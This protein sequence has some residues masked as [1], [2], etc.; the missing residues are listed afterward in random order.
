MIK[1]SNALD[2]IEVACR[3]PDHALLPSYASEHA[4]GIDLRAR[5]SEEKQL[6]PGEILCVPTG[7]SLK[8]PEGYEL[9]IRPRSGLALNYSVTV[10]NSPG[11]IDA[12]YTGEIQVIL[13]HHGTKP[14]TLTPGMRIAQGVFAPIVRATFVLQDT[15]QSTTQRSKWIWLY[16]HALTGHAR[17]HLLVQTTA[18]TNTDHGDDSCALSF[19]GANLLSSHDNA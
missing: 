6:L 1:E 18:W 17:L 2:I 10:L 9:Q 11:T 19:S 12:D 14:L 7:I 8:I 3:C 5:L 15:L 4:S 13:I 16:R